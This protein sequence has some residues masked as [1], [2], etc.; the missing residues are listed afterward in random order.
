MSETTRYYSMSF[1]Q[2]LI[3][4]PLMYNLG[5]KFEVVFNIIK[6]NVT[7]SRGLLEVS[8]TAEPKNL[9]EAIEYLKAR[10]V[11]IS[12]LPSPVTA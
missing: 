5:A 3:K 12:Q 4:E 1:P 11:T 2:Q 9:D 10:G 8:F 6:A 7:E